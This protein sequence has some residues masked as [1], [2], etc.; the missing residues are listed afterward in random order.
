MAEDGG[1]AVE[2]G[3]HDLTAVAPEDDWVLYW[4]VEHPEVGLVGHEG[5]GDHPPTGLEFAADIAS[6]DLSRDGTVFKHLLVARGH[7]DV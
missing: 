5:W 6:P 7:L 1:P 2:Q 4:K 3:V